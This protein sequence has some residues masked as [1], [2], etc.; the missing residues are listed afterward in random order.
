MRKRSEFSMGTSPR[1]LQKTEMCEWRQQVG[2]GKG[3][4]HRERVRGR[5]REVPFSVDRRG[6]GRG[7]CAVYLLVFV[8]LAALR[9]AVAHVVRW[10]LLQLP[11]NV[12]THPLT[13]TH[14]HCLIEIKKWYKQK[15]IARGSRKG[16]HVREHLS[17][18]KSF[19][20]FG[21]IMTF[22]KQTTSRKQ[23]RAATTTKRVCG[24]MKY[25]ENISIGKK[26]VY[27]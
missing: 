6:R 24:Q 17:I 21:V 7:E 3:E 19:I 18:T 4:W 13:H 8:A 26:N 23:Q 10:P 12:Y 1:V 15:K 5:G 16:R 14:W 25:D 22:G 2:V 9:T 20:Y 27:K 11:L